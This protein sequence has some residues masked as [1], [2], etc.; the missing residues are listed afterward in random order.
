[1]FSKLKSRKAPLSLSSV[2]NVIKTSGAKDLSPKEIKG[3]NI[4]L[5]VI[6]QLGIPRSSVV[7][8][9]YDPVQSLL[10]ISTTNNDVRVYGQVNVEVVFEFNLK[11][12]ITFLRFIKGVYLVCWSSGSGLSILSLHSKKI[13]GTYSFSGA[14]TCAEADPSLDFLIFGLNNGSVLFYDVDRMN[15]TPFRIDNLQKKVL[16]KEKMSHVV[17]I[18]WHPRDIGTLLIAYDKCAIIYSLMSGE[19]KNTFTYQLQKGARAFE[20]SSYIL[21]GGKK[22]LF[23]S[24]KDITPDLTSAHFHPNGL[25][26]V[27]THIDNSIVFWDISS[28]T[29]LEARTVFET[30]IHKPGNPIP[31]PAD[32]FNLIEDVKWVCGEDPENTKLLICGGDAH[33]TNVVHVLDF[34]YTLKYSLTSYDKQSE[35]YASPQLGQRMIPITFYLNET[36]E[37]EKLVSIQPMNDNGL[38]YFHGGHNPAYLLLVSNLGQIY[39]VLFSDNAGGQGSTDLG[40]VVLPTSVSFVH[41]PLTSYNLEEVFRMDWYSIVSSRQSTGASSKVR[42][43]LIG[44]ASVNI[45]FL[46]KPIGANDSIRNILITGHENGLVR[47]L[48][49]TKGEQEQMENIVQVG[50]RET[51]YDH[52]DPRSLR[53]KFVSCAFQNRELLVGLASGEVVICKFGKNTSRGTGIPQGKDY[54]DTPIHHQNGNAKLLDISGRISGSI[55]SS[56][57]FLPTNLL[58]VEPSENISVMKM[59]KVGFAAIGYKSGRLVVC[60]IS[61]GPAVILNLERVSEHLSTVTGNCYPTAIEFS[62]ME[63]GNDGYSSIL[64]LVGTNC[65]GNLLVFKI[66]PMGNG[67]FE[68]VFATRTIQ[69]NYRTSDPANA[70]ASCISEIIP[71]N[72]EDGTSAVATMD[73]FTRLSQ[74]VRIPGYVITTSDRDVRVLSLPKTKLS[75]KVVEDSC[76]KCSV[77]NFRDQGVVLAILVKSG[78]VKFCSLPALQDIVDIKLPKEVYSQVRGSLESGLAQQSN[79]L[80]T[81]ELYVRSSKTESVYISVY[82]KVKFKGGDSTTDLLFNATAVIPPR[83]TASALSWAKGQASYMTTAELTAL[84]A[85]PNRGHPKTKESELAFNI[86]PEANT[87]QGYGGYGMQQQHHQNQ[88]QQTQRP[89]DPPVRRSTAG[90]GGVGSQGFM[91]RIQD[92]IQQVEETFNDYA[93]SVTENVTEGLADQKKSFYSSALKSKVGL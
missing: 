2:S 14:I 72:S 92:G 93:N 36:N 82:E 48:D 68:V 6:N 41:P 21:H 35:F 13:L 32:G 49:V 71:I 67:G 88:Q 23:S 55:T 76:L 45:G 27:T 53:V 42:S 24:S 7:A 63:Y 54:H 47:I 57:S 28:P 11:H 87:A 44:G 17:A 80:S 64:L 20:Y 77:V 15:L 86:S 12:P 50:L 62:I 39:F 81:G 22:K 65:G 37:K 9:A 69:L 78:F 83:P 43:L 33:S 75:H 66:N 3:K 25:H 40:R 70:E 18:E 79:L 30:H 8:V 52:G 91:R 58:Q 4:D 38:P 46:P 34:G 74:G 56:A 61:R 90:S 31:I 59:S 29:P 5:K 89:Y 16:P 73:N 10:A 84:I 19:I 60:D 1:M 85:G 26:I 51:L